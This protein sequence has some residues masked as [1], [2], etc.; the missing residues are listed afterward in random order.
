MP[1]VGS[2]LN[3]VQESPVWIVWP[4]TPLFSL[5]S[6]FAVQQRPHVPHTYI[7][8]KARLQ[9]KM[10]SRSLPSQFPSE[11]LLTPARPPSHGNPALQS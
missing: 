3:F 7:K 6:G 8:A 11:E 2:N 4:S 10:V 5:S 9:G 1:L